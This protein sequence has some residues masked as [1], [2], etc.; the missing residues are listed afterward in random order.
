MNKSVEF[1][2]AEFTT[3]YPELNAEY[4]VANAS[5]DTASLILNNT[6]DSYVCCGCERERL[7]YLLCAHI[8]AL[9][10]RGAGN[11]GSISN[12]SEG[13]VSVGFNTGSI[14]SLGAGWYEQTQ[15][16]LLFWMSTAKY[17]SGFYIE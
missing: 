6:L 17:R 16:G 1:D 4:G 11:V 7:L 13:S 5:F 9:R 3:L 14:G 12:A 10:N 8:L 15:Y 2:Y